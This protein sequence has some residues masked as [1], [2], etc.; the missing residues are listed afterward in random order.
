MRFASV[1]AS[2]IDLLKH[3]AIVANV[4]VNS[5]QNWTRNIEC[6][7]QHGGNFIW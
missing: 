7:F 5:N 6:L 4:D 3:P 1:N 2:L